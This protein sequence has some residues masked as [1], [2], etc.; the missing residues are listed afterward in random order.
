MEHS[1]V[2]TTSSV[3]RASIAH[4]GNAQWER[5]PAAVMSTREGFCTGGVEWSRPS[6]VVFPTTIPFGRRRAAVNRP[7]SLNESGR[8][9]LHEGLRCHLSVILPLFHSLE[10]L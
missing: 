10:S 1:N 3:V 5:S 8:G 2:M 7:R 9:R 6:T 4:A